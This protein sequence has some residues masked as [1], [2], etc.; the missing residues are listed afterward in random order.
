MRTKERLWKTAC[1]GRVMAAVIGGEVHVHAWAN[2]DV[3][4]PVADHEVRKLP[5]PGG[6]IETLDGMGRSFT[7]GDGW[8][9]AWSGA[10]YIRVLNLL[11]VEEP[12][13]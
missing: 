11:E 9:W 7:T 2:A 5:V 6:A 4:A 10:E 3:R 13:K 1:E 12:A 8:F